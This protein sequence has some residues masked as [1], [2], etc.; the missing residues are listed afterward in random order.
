M[1]QTYQ[2]KTNQAEGKGLKNKHK[3]WMERLIYLHSQES[4]KSTKLEAII[5]AQRTLV[6]D[7]EEPSL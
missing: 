6:T 5:Y 4:H 2:N 3:I 1:K 7:V